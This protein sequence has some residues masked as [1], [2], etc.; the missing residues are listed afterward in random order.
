MKLT[1]QNI[2]PQSLAVGLVFQMVLL[3][4]S[5]IGFSSLHFPTPARILTIT[6]GAMVFVTL[7]AFVTIRI[8]GAKTYMRPTRFVVDI[9][10]LGVLVLAAVAATIAFKGGSNAR[11]LAVLLVTFVQPLYEGVVYRGLMWHKT[12]K[13]LN[14]KWLTW[15]M[16]IVVVTACSMPYIY[17]IY[18]LL[19][20]MGHSLAD[21]A[22]IALVLAVYGVAT[23]A[24]VG[25]VRAGV[26]NFTIPMLVH[27][28]LNVALMWFV[29][30]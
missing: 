14:N 21:P 29:I 6:M 10:I 1:K 27:S 25:A 12:Q 3:M 28:L 30:L 24:V 9:V 18:V 26:H 22:N 2:L 15:L 7:A 13:V 16:H 8:N 5:A 20:E 4:I 17:N 11:V 19:L 23:N